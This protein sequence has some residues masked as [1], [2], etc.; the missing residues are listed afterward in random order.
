MRARSRPPGLPVDIN[1]YHATWFL[2]NI[3]IVPDSSP[4]MARWRKVIFTTMA[5]NAANPAD[6][7]RLPAERVVSI[8]A[9]ISF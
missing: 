8:G 6:Y 1:P 4:G 2:S 3:A 9:R 5:R 7:F